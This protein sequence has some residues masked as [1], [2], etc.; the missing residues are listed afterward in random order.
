VNGLLEQRLA[1]EQRTE[2]FGQ[3]ISENFAGEGTEAYSVTPGKNHRSA[4]GVVEI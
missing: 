1:F 2:L 3:M 4:S